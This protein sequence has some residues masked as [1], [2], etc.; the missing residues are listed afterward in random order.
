MKDKFKWLGQILSTG[1]LAESAAA[2]VEA[3]EGKIR[4]AC[5][6]ISYIVN[7]WRARVVGGME[8]ALLLWELCCIPSLLHGAGTWVD[9]SAATEKQLN[10]IQNWYFRLVL[11]VGPGASLAAMSW[12]FM[13]LDSGHVHQGQN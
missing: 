12:D 13:M 7:D 3:R 9:I 8:T 2:T 6:E 5:L 10:K 11:Q 1:G 4:G